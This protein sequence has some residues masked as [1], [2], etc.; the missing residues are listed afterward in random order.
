MAEM[1]RRNLLK[2][3]AA[4]GAGAGAIAGG[5]P[6]SHADGG[7]GSFNSDAIGSADMV[8][9]NGHV[10]TLGVGHRHA[11]AIAIKDGLVVGVGNDASIRR[12]KGSK[13]EVVDARGG[14]V[15]PGIN[16]SHN[17]LA[18]LGLSLPPYQL[19][20]NV[21][22]V[23]ELQAIIAAAV[24][25]ALTPDQWIR[26]RG[27]QE[28]RIPQA[29]TAADIDPV[30]GS[31]P[32]VLN[33]FSAH[34]VSGNTEAMRRAGITRDTVAPPGG[35]IDRD[36]DGNPTGVFR[37]TA[38][39]LLTRAVPG[40]TAEERAAALDTGIKLLQ[41]CGI[42]SV[43]EPGTGN[44]TAYR[45]KAAAGTLGLRVTALLSGGSTATSMRNAIDRLSADDTD[46]RWVRV[47]GFKIFADGIP[48]QRTAWMNEPYPDGSRGSL[49]IGGATHEAQLQNLKDMIELATQAGMQVGTHACGDATTDAAVNAYAASI[50]NL[51]SP[52]DLRHYV[53]HCNFPSAQ[54]L[55]TM[56]ANG[57]GANMNAEILYLQ[58]RILDP[59]I[60]PELTSYQWPYR[61]AID[62][63]VNVSTGS[64]A[65]VVEF[66]W[67]RGVYAATQRQGEDGSVAGIEQAIS[68]HEV[69]STYTKAGA[70][71]DHAE[72]W[73][74]TLDVGMAAD[75]AIVD[76][77]L[78]TRDPRELLEM[79]VST[80]LVDGKVVYHRDTAQGK[81]AKKM[82]AAF[83][84]S[85]R[86]DPK[87][88]RGEQCCCEAAREVTG[89]S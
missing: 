62:A 31:H 16:D 82:H 6:A 13:T 88:R 52:S 28:L 10:L 68:M 34:A 23:A 61:S 8:I 36:A 53:I 43:T 80:T 86:N 58:G 66:N 12:F 46:P 85:R 3:A 69:L 79:E 75:V 20:V 14:T 83:A 11:S 40:R 5:I 63:G 22:S 70:H 55:A 7:P 1:H 42:T 27:W 17:H 47:A 84:M 57:I 54:T 33:D 32:V 81:A 35:V 87:S 71:Q 72:S 21:T 48:R 38:Q 60:G 26:G 4:I 74:G 9:H 51:G 65:P 2:G 77:D 64:D 29:P 89:D 41:S 78:L 76:G 19:D 15:I 44:L 67:L 73:K 59:I 49:T 25:V 30:S 50:A 37:E 18:A 45:Q 24:A 39:G 56:A